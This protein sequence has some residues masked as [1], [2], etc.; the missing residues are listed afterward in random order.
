MVMF[1]V[2]V[3]G[4]GIW[5]WGIYLVNLEEQRGWLLRVA[6]NQ[7]R[8][9]EAVANFDS[10]FSQQDHPRG[11]WGATLSQIRAAHDDNP[12]FGKTG[13]FVLA[14]IE[15]ED[16]VFLLKRRFSGQGISGKVPLKS[17]L[18]EPMLHALQ[19]QSGTLIGT[20]YRNVRVLAAYEPIQGM[21]MGIVAKIDMAEIRAPFIKVGIVAGIST[22]LL[23][24]IGAVISR[25]ISVPLID[26]LRESEERKGTILQSAL[27]AIIT[28]EDDGTVLEFNPAAEIIFGYTADQAKGRNIADLIIPHHLRDKHRKGL[29]RYLETGENIIIGKQIEIPAI[30][31]DGSEFPIEL[32]ISRIQLKERGLFTAFIR[33]ISEAKSYQLALQNAKE[34]AERANLA[35]SEFLASMSHDLRTPLNAIMGFSEMMNIKTFGPLGDSH[36]EGY[37][38][39][40]HESGKLLVSLI[41]D[42]LDISKVE[43]GKYELFEENLDVNVLIQ[44][45]VTMI[46][47]LAETARTYLATNIEPGLPLLHG[48]E[49]SL[50]QVLNNL[51]SNAIKFT[52]EN[53]KIEISANISGDG[54]IN[55]QVTD[56]GIGMS[57]KNIGKALRPFEQADS[58][59]A[60][61]H[62][63]TG[64]GLHLCQKLMQLHGGTIDIESTIDKGTT[65][66]VTF[67]A[68]RT[69]YA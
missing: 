57:A 11:S 8:L 26:S 14:R 5:A 7:A 64:L 44:S 16:I 38:T 20:D 34:D 6:Q 31:S 61:R 27:D 21:D 24:V 13:E 50:I 42:I 3:I 54:C 51:L 33:D 62:E 40:I 67:P 43:A 59:H 41:D 15:G 48:D 29:K 23:I 18:A 53:G 4:A 37:A 10:Q 46:S 17:G 1:A 19:G 63:G 68:T 52:P 22:L 55:I 30:R 65:I 36:Y 35:K 12:G 56:T 9:I 49:R 45:S 39:D 58:I 32:T 25:G 47:T 2:A 28:I 60:K 69:V 66:T